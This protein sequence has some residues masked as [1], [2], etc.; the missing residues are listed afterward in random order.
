MS[1]FIENFEKICGIKGY[2]HKFNLNIQLKKENPDNFKVYEILPNGFVLKPDIESK[3]NGIIHSGLF[4]HGVLSKKL[5]DTPQAINLIANKLNI[6]QNWI[7]YAGL[8]DSLGDTHQRI[9]IFNFD[10]GE[11]NSLTFNKFKVHSLSRQLYEVNLGDLQGN[12]FEI[13]MNSTETENDLANLEKMKERIQEITESLTNKGFPNFF[14]LQRFG[15]KRPITHFIGRLLLQGKIEEAVKLYLTKTSDLENEKM[16]NSRILLAETWNYAQFLY[17]IPNQYKYEYLISKS[18]LKNPKNFKKAFNQIPNNIKKLFIHAY[19]SYIFNS[20]LSYLIEKKD[21]ELMLGCT[22]P[23]INSKV[24]L[25]SL[26]SDLKDYLLYTL[27]EENISFSNF[28]NKYFHWFSNK[29]INRDVII[30][31]LKLK[32]EIK[33]RH[34]KLKFSLPKSTYA[35]MLIRE[36]EKRL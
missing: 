10:E 11:I 8:K 3:V 15:S 22:L 17:N 21:E 16:R 5:I 32:I 23:L 24:N 28:E 9:S 18:L 20:I 35:T 19:Q 27:S 13:L 25:N 4:F 29:N 36:L 12:Q 2:F 30:R 14:G 26:S 34:M 1:V 6:P 33:D 31:P 7:G